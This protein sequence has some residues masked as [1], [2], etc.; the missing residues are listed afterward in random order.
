MQIDT[1]TSYMPIM[2]PTH[3]VKGYQSYNYNT[4]SV[5]KLAFTLADNNLIAT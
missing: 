2:I 5:I 4:H 3:K 1:L